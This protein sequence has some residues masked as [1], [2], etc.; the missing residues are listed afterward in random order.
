M[1]IDNKWL[2][3]ALSKARSQWS[4]D[5]IELANTTIYGEPHKIYLAASNGI[6]QLFVTN[7]QRRIIVFILDLLKGWR[8]ASNLKQTYPEWYETN[9]HLLTHFA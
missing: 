8:R 2:D 5:Y 4:G 7:G 1:A 3:L 6:V 9:S